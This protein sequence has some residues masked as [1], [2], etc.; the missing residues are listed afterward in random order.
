MERKVLHEIPPVQDGVFLYIADRHKSAFDYPIHNHEIFELNFVEN[1]RGV[2]RIVG[3]STETIGDYDLVL[4]T[5][6]NLEHCWEQGECTSENIREV[7]IQFYLNFNSN[8]GVLQSHS[9]ETIRKMFDRARCGLAFP[10][11]AIMKVYN[12]LDTISQVQ[13][14]FYAAQRFFAILYELSRC[15]GAH[16]LSSSSFARTLAESDS[17]RIM[18]VKQFID[19]HYHDDIR[20]EQLAD[21][22]NMTPTAFSRYFKKRTG[23]TLREYIIDI[24]LGFAIRKLVDSTDAVSEICYDCGFNTLSNFNRLFKERKGCNP[25][26][27][28]EKYQK[29]RVIF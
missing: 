21:M 29:T 28:R 8:D 9:F 22:V 15:E 25:T 10:L 18:K 23:K 19:E 16:E 7:T 4:I 12:K 2:H 13:D 3:D 5:A 11:H 1:A 26:E 24:R 14:R 27:F 6:P 17:R 20:L